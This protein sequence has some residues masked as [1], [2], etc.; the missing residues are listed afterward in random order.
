MNTTE[1]DTT[2][3]GKPTKL[4]RLLA[5]LPE[6]T[7]QLMACQYASPGLNAKSEPFPWYPKGHAFM[8]SDDPT[9]NLAVAVRL[10]ALEIERL[11][12]AKAT[13]A[14]IPATQY[15]PMP[16]L[17]DLRL[18][19][20]AKEHNRI[21]KRVVQG[22][23]IMVGS[24]ILKVCARTYLPDN[25]PLKGLRLTFYPWKD[26]GSI[27]CGDQV[28]IDGRP[29]LVTRADPPDEIQPNDQVWLTLDLAET[30][31]EDPAT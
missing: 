19:T 16:P 27:H 18:Y 21:D 24:E 30:A 2:D 4:Y 6:G 23:P 22:I 31:P 11:Q 3:L 25:G 8:P 17:L 7:L 15:N 1:T 20:T 13:P 12:L 5:T 10:L 26:P 29:Y 28:F 14:A 9:E